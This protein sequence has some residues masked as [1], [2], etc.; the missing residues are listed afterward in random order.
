MHS[1]THLLPQVHFAAGDGSTERLELLVDAGADLRAV[2]ASGGNALHWAAGK[3][4]TAAMRYILDLPA[5]KRPD[6]N[7]AAPNG[8]P[9]I[10]LAAVNGSD[11]GV[12]LLLEAGAEVAAATMQGGLTLLHI[13]AENGLESATLSLLGDARTAAAAKELAN[14]LTAAPFEN[15]PLHLACMAGEGRRAVVAALLA[16]TSVQTQAYA[17]D[18]SAAIAD[19]K[20]LLADWTAKS[21]AAAA[22]LAATKKAEAEAAAA[23]AASDGSVFH[24]VPS[25]R[26]LEGTEAAATPEI[27]AQATALKEAG[28]AAY[29]PPPLCHPLCSLTIFIANL[30]L[31][32]PRTLTNRPN[33]YSPY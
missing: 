20:R 11:A 24:Y 33:R 1:P 32:L 19:G 12:L 28:N 30:F 5:N 25:T 14:S 6:I 26:E 22:A 10:F 18:A 2:S 9:P 17:G 7:A 13:A 23:A 27:Q 21:E 31:V 16:V 8:L 4:R 15:T 29:V 3:G